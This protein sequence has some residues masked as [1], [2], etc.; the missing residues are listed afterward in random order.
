MTHDM[1]PLG[2]LLV[3][4]GYISPSQLAE[5][6]TF[7][8]RLPSGQKMTLGEVL[9]AFEY[10]TEAQ[11]KEVIGL[12]EPPPSPN[13]EILLQALKEEGLVN[14]LQIM[15]AKEQFQR[16][17][18]AN[19]RLGTLLIDLGYATRAAIE[20]AMKSYYDKEQERQ[21]QLQEA[22]NYQNKLLT[23]TMRERLQVSALIENAQDKEA[24]FP[25]G[26]ILLEKK[27]VTE[28][29]LKDA[30]EYQC[31]L[32]KINHQPLGEILVT[33]GY[34]SKH[35][36]DEA[37]GIQPKFE[38]DPIGQALVK[39]GVIVDWQLSHA[40]KLQFG[41]A[42]PKRL[43]SIIVELGY[44]TRE[45]IENA[46]NQ[47]YQQQTICETQGHQ[48]HHKSQQPLG[49]ILVEKNFISPEQLE[50]ALEYQNHLPR[51]Y[52]PLG[53]IMILKGL[54]S[55]EQ[56]QEALS[57]QPAFSHEPIGQILIKE[58]VIQEWQLAHALCLQ[59]EP[60]T[61][62]KNIGTVLVELGYASHEAIEAALNHYH[63]QKAL[64]P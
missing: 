1:I 41:S 53:D 19:K 46:V 36:L 10:L 57:S 2:Q 23:T 17:N 45:I 14:D 4:K 52:I 54:I 50:F 40:L 24:P 31:R 62:P 43:G 27:W 39:Q 47:Y 49:Q 3:Q 16:H 38:M 56:L 33:L 25:L 11:L 64:T 42:N 12:Q 20:K 9:L 61:K 18:S 48:P 22:A 58:K 7:Q 59:Y 35:Q 29:D 8:H 34:I 15:E 30:L 60:R 51:R 13:E 63:Q 26:Q 21:R 55:E 32:P 6:M 44:A 28:S 5:A 37:L